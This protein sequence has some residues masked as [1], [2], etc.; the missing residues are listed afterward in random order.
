MAGKLIPDLLRV[1]G[2][3]F[4]SNSF[5]VGVLIVE[6]GRV[7][8]P[9]TGAKS[10]LTPYGSCPL[11]PLLIL[12]HETGPTDAN[13]YSCW[14]YGTQCSNLPFQEIKSLIKDGYF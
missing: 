11:N 6:V 7:A 14:S 4:P 13:I 5:F 3:P 10:A 8:T 12:L 1:S 9:K 2:I